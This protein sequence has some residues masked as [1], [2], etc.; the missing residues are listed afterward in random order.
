MCNF[1]LLDEKKQLNEKKKQ[2]FNN[3]K[4]ET[5]KESALAFEKRREEIRKRNEQE[6]KELLEKKKQKDALK[7]IQPNK[8][9]ISTKLKTNQVSNEAVQNYLKTKD[10][11]KISKPSNFSNKPSYISGSN[12]INQDIS[13]TSQANPYNSNRKTKSYYDQLPNVSKKKIN[14]LDSNSAIKDESTKKATFIKNTT[15]SGSLKSLMSYDQILKMADNCHKES[16]ISTP[17]KIEPKNSNDYSNLL[18]GNNKLKKSV[19]EIKMKYEPKSDAHLRT[20]INKTVDQ[21]KI[22]KAADQSKLA[23]ITSGTSAW[24]RIIS[25]M[26]KKPVQKSKSKFFLIKKYY[27]L[28]FFSF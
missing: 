19:E 21:S 22:S 10:N 11:S 18:Y 4:I 28:S 7:N 15:S 6:A 9:T 17:N 1:Q 3:T 24:D 12:K 13:A 16:K 14:K 25:D 8:K 5:T 23:P 20:S 27:K 26:K 2:N